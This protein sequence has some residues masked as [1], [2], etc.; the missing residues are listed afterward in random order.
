MCREKLRQTRS[1]RQPPHRVGT[2]TDRGERGGE[3]VTVSARATATGGR[4]GNGEGLG[5][6]SRMGF[7][8]VHESGALA[9]SEP[10]KIALWIARKAHRAR[11]V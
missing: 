11:R 6:V 4:G 1:S 2:W 8:I 3:G 9:T 7:V 5:M 10:F